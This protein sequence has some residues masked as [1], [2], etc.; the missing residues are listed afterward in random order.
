[1]VFGLGK[2][3]GVGVTWDFIDVQIEVDTSRVS[4]RKRVFIRK[5]L[6]RSC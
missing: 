5:G 4:K 2:L 3:F 1:M 6:L